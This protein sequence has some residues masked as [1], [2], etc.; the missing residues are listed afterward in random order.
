MISRLFSMTL[1]FTVHHRLIDLHATI[2][3]S[4]LLFKKSIFSVL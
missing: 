1:V 4:D 2:L 3:T